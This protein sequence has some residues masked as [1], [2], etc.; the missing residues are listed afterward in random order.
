MKHPNLKDRNVFAV[1]VGDMF[2]TYDSDC[3]LVYSP[4]A[5]VF[6]LALPAQVDE[7]E[8]QAA[9]GEHGE[10]LEKLCSYTPLKEKNPFGVGCDATSTLYLLLNEKCNF[11]CKYCYSAEGRSNQELSMEQIETALGYFLSA[12]RNAPSTRTVMFMGGGEPTLSWHLV[13]QAT[14]FAEK[15][16]ARNGVALKKQMSTNGSILTQRMIDYYKEHDFELQFSFDVLPDVQD[17]QRGQFARVSENL[18]RLGEEGVACRIRSTVTALNVE[19]MVEMVEF[20]H[21]E[22]LLVRHLT[23]EHVVDP[24]NFTTPGIIR[25]FYD[26]YFHSF[27]QAQTLA[28]EYGIDLFSTSQGTIR[29]LRDRFCFNLYCLTPYGTMTTCPNISSPL[30]DGYAKAVFGSV[31]ADGIAFDDVSYASLTGGNIDTY[32]ECGECW[33]R[34]NCGGGCPNQR[35]VYEPAVFGESCNFMRRMLRYN[36]LSEMTGKHRKATGRDLFTEIGAVLQKR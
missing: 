15:E 10:I 29:T 16:A 17:G 7:L 8:K 19:R 25:D 32:P 33:A 34:W 36:L 9:E 4:L 20:C 13:E 11:H 12:E 21:R 2:Q 24:A 3:F 30:E 28:A 31:E 5:N 1:P 27:I 14:A 23:C 35:R 6:F 26:R 18:K 22:Y